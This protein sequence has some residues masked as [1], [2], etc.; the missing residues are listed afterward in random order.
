MA[1]KNYLYGMSIRVYSTEYITPLPPQMLD[2]LLTTLPP[3][4]SVKAQRFR[5]WQDAYGSI[6]GRLLLTMAIK[7]QCRAFHFHQLQYTQ[8]GKPWLP[9]GPHFNISHSAHRVVCA[10]SDERIGIDLEEIKQLQ[11]DDFKDQFSSEE[12]QAITTTPNPLMA[13]YQG[14]T[15]KESLIKADGAGLHIPLSS[16]NILSDRPIRLNLHTWHL[17]PLTRWPGYA[18]HLASETPADKVIIKEIPINSLLTNH[19]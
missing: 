19:L 14:W 10:I 4:L 9:D 12:W 17:H 13:F 5:R 18:C 1:G 6:F 3:D 7:E 16:V 11:I 15:A 2:P 8:F